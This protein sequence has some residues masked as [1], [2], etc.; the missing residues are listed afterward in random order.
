MKHVLLY[1]FMIITVV[2]MVILIN[3]NEETVHQKLLSI[4]TY[5]SFI[6]HENEQMYIDI[7]LSDQDHILTSIDSYES[8]EVHNKSDKKSMVLSLKD[9]IYQHDE[10]YLNETFYKYTYII[11]MPL[12]GYDFDI[13]DCYLDIKLI[14]GDHYD[15]YIGSLSLKTV[16]ETN[17]N[18]L[19]WTALSGRKKT[20]T[21]IS[22]IYEIDIEY[23]SIKQDIIEISIG[24]LYQ[25]TYELKDDKITIQIPFEL[26]LFNACPIIITF[27]DQSISIINYFIYMKD[28]ETLKQSG[29][30]IYHYALN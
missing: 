20:N 21:Y 29:Q 22:R 11:E 7:Y 27:E 28:F 19:D 10:V 30:L 24:N 4:D 6:D 8:L 1:M 18:S 2:F 5:Y 13:E 3:K 12:L 17:E 23:V 25:I 9:V 16:E 26:K 14:N 15:I